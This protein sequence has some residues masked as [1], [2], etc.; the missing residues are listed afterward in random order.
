MG[1]GPKGAY[2][3]LTEIFIE[4]FV[5][6]ERFGTDFYFHEK[7]F[8]LHGKRSGKTVQIGDKIEV[9]IARTNPH[10]LQIELEPVQGSRKKPKAEKAVKEKEVP[11]DIWTL[12]DFE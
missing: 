8:H 5:P 3:E 7:L 12:E 10:L 6:I 9:Q 4:G 1:L 2:V 11:R